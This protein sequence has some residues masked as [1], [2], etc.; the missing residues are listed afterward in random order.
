MI[1]RSIILETDRM[2]LYEMTVAD[3]EHFYT[4]NDDPEVIQYT[5]NARFESVE[6]A[7][8]FLAN[9]D[10]YRVHGMGRWGMWLRSEDCF[11]GWCG[12]K[13]L[14][15]GE[16]DLGYRLLK[17]HWGVGLATEASIACLR[18]GFETLGLQTI[19]GRSMRANTASIRVLEKIGMHYWK[20]IVD[21]L[22][23]GVCYRIDK[24]S[25]LLHD[26]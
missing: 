4:L 15:G 2:F 6:E 1:D 20:E 19:I 25:F 14:E 11:V 24:S 21:D 8:S 26:S 10:H 16:V 22:H 5:G 7:K 23:D 12:L 9:Y 18:Y 13:R 17:Q 3:A